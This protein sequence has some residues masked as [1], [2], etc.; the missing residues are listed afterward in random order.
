MADVRGV[1]LV[2]TFLRVGV[3]AELQYRVNVVLSIVQSLVAVGTSLAVLAL[4]FSHTDSLGGWSGDDSSWQ[5]Q[6]GHRPDERPPPHRRPQET[7]K[8]TT[9][10]CM[11]SSFAARGRERWRWLRSW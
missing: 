4:V 7:S 8:P 9:A 1:R 3:Q 6:E 11:W 2:A 5:G 10:G